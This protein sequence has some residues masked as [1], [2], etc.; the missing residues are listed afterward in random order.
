MEKK[1]SYLKEDKM[2][3]VKEWIKNIK[4]SLW[5]NKI[6]LILGVALGLVVYHI[7]S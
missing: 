2:K 3:T 4:D 1:D 7:A 6:P 5:E